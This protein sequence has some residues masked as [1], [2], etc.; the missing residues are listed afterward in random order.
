MF[1]ILD[2]E[3]TCYD[4]GMIDFDDPSKFCSCRPRDEAISP[5]D[6]DDEE[7]DNNNG[8]FLDKDSGK[9]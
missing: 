1:E 5:P 9:L 3:K 2:M 4:I 8:S 7:E 6:N